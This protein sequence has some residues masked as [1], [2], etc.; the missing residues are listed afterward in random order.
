MIA[1][2]PGASQRFLHAAN[3]IS[4]DSP[5]LCF[6]SQLIDRVLL[7]GVGRCNLHKQ[8]VTGDPVLR[9]DIDKIIQLNESTDERPHVD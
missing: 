5:E 1:D 9:S 8:L 2:Q 4:I 6:Q 3:A 7:H